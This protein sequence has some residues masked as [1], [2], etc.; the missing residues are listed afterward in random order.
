MN[1]ESEKDWESIVG[2]FILLCGEIELRLLQLYWNIRLNSL[3]YD[4]EMKFKSMVWKAKHIRSLMPD[5]DLSPETKKK[6]KLVI[7][8]TI[9]LSKARNLVAH[10]PLCMDYFYIENGTFKYA[11]K[12]RSLRND[13]N[14]ISKPM[15]EKE[16]E[17]AKLLS[18]EFLKVM[19]IA[20]S[21]A[22][23]R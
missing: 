9:K 14:H 22:V 2:E 18:G 12:I 13:E 23:T 5:L 3:P 21:E 16:I 1:G 4:E 7:N 6:I 17:E 19:D 11:P 20:G 15:L 8:K 10:N